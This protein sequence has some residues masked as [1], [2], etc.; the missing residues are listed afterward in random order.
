MT[1]DQKYNSN[2]DSEIITEEEY[3]ELSRLE[4]LT[5]ESI[6]YDQE[7]NTTIDDM[8]FKKTDQWVNLSLRRMMRYAAEHGFDRIAWTTGEMQVDMYDFSKRVDRIEYKVKPGVLPNSKSYSLNVFDKQGDLVKS[9]QDLNEEYIEEI[10]GKELA[11][12]IANGEGYS[13]GDKKVLSG[14]DLKVGG[15]GMKAFYDKIIPSAAS[16][17]GKPFGAKVE[18]IEIDGADE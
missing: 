16:K 18:L 15:E 10:I 7:R 9:E 4:D 2:W 13:K 17:L 3:N 8:P 1:L 5:E 14:L 12:K 6:D 11:N